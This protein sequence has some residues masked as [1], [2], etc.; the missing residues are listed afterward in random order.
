MLL[1]LSLKERASA[2]CKAFWEGET[3]ITSTLSDKRGLSGGEAVETWGAEYL[4][5]YAM[6]CSSFITNT[7][8]VTHKHYPLSVLGPRM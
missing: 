1:L 6:F 4:S 5:K 8:S 3:D 2:G 7:S